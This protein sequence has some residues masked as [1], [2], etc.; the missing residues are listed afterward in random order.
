MK[1]GKNSQGFTIVELLIVIVVIAILA[2]VTIVA[3][4]GVSNRAKAA[5]AQ[6]AVSQ[7]AKKIMSYAS[8]NNDQFPA[9]LSDGGVAD[10]GGMVFQYSYDNSS[11]PRKFCITATGS[12]V[13]Y[14]KNNTT[15]QSPVAG[16]C[17]GHGLNGS[18]SITNLATNP[19][20]LVNTNG[21]N[22][23]SSNSQSYSATGGPSGSGAVTATRTGTVGSTFVEFG[24]TNSATIYTPVVAGETYTSSFWASASNNSSAKY[25]ILTRFYDAGGS[26]VDSNSSTGC[27]NYPDNTWNRWSR[28]DV[29][30]ANAVRIRI[31]AI[32][33]TNVAVGTSITMSQVMLTQ[34][35]TL[36]TYADGTSPN[37]VWNGTANASS[38]SGTPL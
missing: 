17:P 13:S 5:A 15:Q 26:Q 27:E 6:S 32:G 1:V 4:N 12:N 30:P 10:N 2:A 24:L 16:A 34:G 11:S 38:S 14:F 25:C 19:G 8:I 37:W 35:S 31:I 22:V 3:Y 20:A 28:T 21:W 36:Y 9:T 23:G 33:G 29:A 7:A 18:P